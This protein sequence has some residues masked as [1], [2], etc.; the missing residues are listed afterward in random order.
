MLEND[1]RKIIPFLSETIQKKK[2]REIKTKL[3]VP[4]KKDN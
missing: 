2:K 1:R 4:M 3:S